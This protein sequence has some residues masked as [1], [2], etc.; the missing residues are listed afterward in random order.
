MITETTPPPK[1]IAV[2][3]TQYREWLSRQGPR[4]LDL[5]WRL[6]HLL[7]RQRVLLRRY[8]PDGKRVLDFGCMDGV[9]TLRL[10]QLGGE[11]VGFD[12]SP[13]AIAQAERFRGSATLPRFTTVPPGPGQF[14]LV[15]CNEVLE[16]VPDD[17]A[18]I[19]ELLGFL[20]P[21]GMLVGTTPVGR[22]FW[23]P[24]HKRLY[25]EPTLERTLAPWG[26]VRIRRYYRTPIRN[27]LPV[28]QSGAA[29]FIFEVKP[30]SLQDAH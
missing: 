13:A 28:R 25:D 22:Y 17:L 26:A 8:R 10:Q 6:R 24:D 19:G 11:A 20:A 1:S 3:D 29:V 27:L 21:G 18:F 16:H 4:A 23:D 9:F 12:L 7:W 5:G 2:Y 15:Y 14:D 30:R